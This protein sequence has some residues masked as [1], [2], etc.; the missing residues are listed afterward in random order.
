MPCEGKAGVALRSCPCWFARCSLAAVPFGHGPCDDHACLT[1]RLV[2]GKW[3]ATNYLPRSVFLARAKELS[4]LAEIE[5][6]PRKTS[7]AQL[8]P[9]RVVSPVLITAR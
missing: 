8:Q 5:M 2:L 7:L 3:E 6:R 4:S 9:N 1:S